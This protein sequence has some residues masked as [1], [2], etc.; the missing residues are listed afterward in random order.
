MH[1]IEK[2]ESW[3]R[4]AALPVAAISAVFT[5]CFAYSTMSD[6]RLGFALGFALAICT[7]ASAY[8]WTVRSF[9]VRGGASASVTT[10]ML[11]AG[12]LFTSMDA[13]TNAGSL[14]WQRAGAA[15]E[16]QVTNIRY[17]DGRRAVEDAEARIKMMTA[18]I[19][20]LKAA[21]PWVTT[22]SA[23]GLKGRIPALEEAVAQEARRGGCGPRCLK[24]KEELAGLMDQIGK[25]EQLGKHESMLAAAHRSL[26]KAREIASGRETIVSATGSQSHS[27]ARLGTLVAFNPTLDPSEETQEWT[28]Y[29]VGLLIAVFLT[30][31]PMMLN[32]VGFG[33]WRDSFKKA[34]QDET[35]DGDA[36]ALHAV[37]AA[38]GQSTHKETTVVVDDRAALRAIVES[39]KDRLPAPAARAA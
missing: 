4:V 35:A 14:L 11:V 38:Q 7:F 32:W 26:E 19:D 8:I 37:Q 1:S 10:A 9:A 34:S 36:S 25:A 3:F 39:L 2:I 5:V 28:S 29:V 33:A 12:I 6:W 27:L 22:V 15:N 24:L 13:L 20:E 16:A 21:N 18:R 17:E 31:G 23:D 30:F